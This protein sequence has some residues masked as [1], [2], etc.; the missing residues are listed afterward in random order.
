[1][2]YVVVAVLLLSFDNLYVFACLSVLK[3]FLARQNAVIIFIE[4][5]DL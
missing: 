5:I 1:M 4:K 3:C 2:F